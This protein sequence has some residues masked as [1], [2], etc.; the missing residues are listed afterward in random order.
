MPPGTWPGG[1]LGHR[2]AWSRAWG[3]PRRPT[4]RGGGRQGMLAGA[5]QGQVSSVRVRRPGGGAEFQ[6]NWAFFFF[7]TNWAFFF[8]SAELFFLRSTC[9][10]TLA[11]NTTPTHAATRLERTRVL[12]QKHKDPRKNRNNKE[13]LGDPCTPLPHRP[14]Q[15]SHTARANAGGEEDSPPLTL[16]QKGHHRHDA[17]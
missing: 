9:V 1:T 8:S 11:R 5:G 12:E 17:L 16:K 3:T 10:F 15:A 13:A 14:P 6:P 4:A 7:E 2:A